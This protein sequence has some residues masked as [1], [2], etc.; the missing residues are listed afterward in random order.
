MIVGVPS[1]MKRMYSWYNCACKLGLKSMWA[2][3]DPDIFGAK[4]EGITDIMF[5]F[6]DIQNML[7]LKELGIEMV[8]L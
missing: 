8:R 5:N 3:Y 7:R 6:E 2:R 4:D 1:D